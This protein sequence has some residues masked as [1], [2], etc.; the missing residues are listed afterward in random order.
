MNET[1]AKITVALVSTILLTLPATVHAF[2]LVNETAVELHA[3]SLD[4]QRFERDVAAGGKMCCPACK[5]QRTT[6]LIV[7]G[8]VPVSG[9]SQPGWRAECRAR[10][11][12]SQTVVVSGGLNR[13]VCQ[14]P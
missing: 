2:C 3:Q 12:R 6:L 4:S 9:N 14:T 11:D 10:V 1:M 13:I 7:T 8:Y 5:R